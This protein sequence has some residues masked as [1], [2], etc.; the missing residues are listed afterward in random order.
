VP[1]VHIDDDVI[2]VNKPAGLIVHPGSGVATGTMVQGLIAQYPDLASVG[3][4]HTRP[5]VVHRL[6]KGTS[7]LLLVARTDESYRHLSEQLAARTVLRRYHTLVWSDVAAAE[8]VVDAPLGRSPRDAT[9]QAVVVGGRFARTHYRVLQR[10]EDPDR[11]LLE[12]RLETGRTHQI[13]VHLD[14]IDHPVC[15]DD[16]YGR[17]RPLDGLTRPFLHAA[18]IGFEHPTTGELL[19]FEAARPA[20]LTNFLAGLVPMG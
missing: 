4:D 9:R 5:G 7:G 3:D 1:I 16:R 18:E 2:V 17:G 12:C 8:G 11:T 6:D 10:Y 14:A 13:R 15:G 20:D 19:H